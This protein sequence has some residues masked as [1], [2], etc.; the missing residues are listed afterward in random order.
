MP[1]KA[2]VSSSKLVS[3][4]IKTLPVRL[5]ND[6]KNNW[7]TNPT[8]NLDIVADLRFTN[9]EWTP[10][11]NWT[12]NLTPRRNYLQGGRPREDDGEKMHA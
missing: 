1:G 10:G 2:S 5:R 8:N 11:T 6:W 12:H 3:E 7:T 9:V 4:L